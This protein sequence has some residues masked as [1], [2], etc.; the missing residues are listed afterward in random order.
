MVDFNGKGRGVIATRSFK[1]GEFVVEYAG[2]LISYPAAKDRE[3][4]YASD[5]GFGCYMYYF[6]YNSKNYW[7]V[8]MFL[9]VSFLPVFN[10]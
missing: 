7:Y 1:K 3:R 6:V 8:L 5:P 4:I 9:S 2:D 10:K